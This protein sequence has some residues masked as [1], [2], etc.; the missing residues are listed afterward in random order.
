MD[1]DAGA[2]HTDFRICRFRSPQYDNERTKQLFQGVDEFTKLIQTA[3][4][5]I[6]D[7]Y[8]VLQRFPSWMFSVTRR[9]KKAHA[10]EKPFFVSN[11]V[12]VKEA[13]KAGTAH[14]CFCLDMAHRQKSE[15][16]SDE[17]AGYISGSLLEAGSETTANIL[18]GFVQAMVLFPEVQKRAQEEIDR[19]VGPNRLPT[20][21]DEPRMQYIRGCVKESMR[22]MP[23]AILGFPHALTKD[24]EYMGYHIPKGASIL[25]NVYTIQMDPARSPNP[26][27]FNPDRFKDD[28]LS[29]ADSA[30]NPDASKRDHYLFGAGRR[31]CQGMHVADRSLFLGISRLLWGFNIEPKIDPVTRQ[32]TFI[33]SDK[34]TEGFVCMPEPFE[35]EIRVRDIG[36]EH[37]MREAW[38]QAGELLDGRTGQWKSA[39]ENIRKSV[40]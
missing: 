24:D 33:D 3:T 35:A 22:W 20:M 29:S 17:Q 31:I 2:F 39:P 18:Y 16:F 19:L 36:R 1:R 21:E 30:A 15:G 34:Y 9:A 32:K 8:P 27:Q 10:K 23:T 5:L 14:P 28:V 40:F 38:A 11:Y 13:I 6:L 26:R 12:E 4:A 25:I 7:A 37:I